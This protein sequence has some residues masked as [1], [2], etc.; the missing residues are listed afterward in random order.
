MISPLARWRRWR[1]YRH[2][3]AVMHDAVA[4]QDYRVSPRVYEEMRAVA[5]LAADRPGEF[6]EIATMLIKRGR[7]RPRVTADEFEAA[8]AER[9]GITVGQLHAQGRYAEPC[10]CGEDGCEGWA[11]GHQWEDA[12]VEDDLRRHGARPWW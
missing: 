4:G 1:R 8:Y 3:L 5:R 6:L 9:S 2:A 10:D 12:I 11:M 7:C